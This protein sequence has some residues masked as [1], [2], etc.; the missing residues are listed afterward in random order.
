M[1]I[2]ITMMM[3]IDDDNNN[4]DDDDDDDEVHIRAIIARRN[5]PH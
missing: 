5:G 2:T 1:P 3:M 4:D